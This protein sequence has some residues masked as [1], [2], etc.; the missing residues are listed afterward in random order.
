MLVFNDPFVASD[1]GFGDT[2]FVAASGNGE[3][4]AFGESGEAD[5][6][7]I[8]MYKAADD[9]IT[10][11][12]PVVDLIINREDQVHGLGL[13]YDGTLGVARGDNAY[14]FT[15]DLRLQGVVP[16]APGGAGAVLHPLHANSVSVDN[17]GAPYRPDS[18]LAFVASGDH[19]IDIYDTFHFFKLGQIAIRDVVSGP[20]RAALPFPGDNDGFTCPATVDV[21]DEDGN[22]IGQTLQIF[23]NGNPDTPWE[24]DGGAG[25]NE[26]RC[27]VLKLFGVTDTGGVVVVNVR[28]SDILRN[29]PA[30]L[31]G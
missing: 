1:L 4:V 3:Y 19:T 28:K 22:V 31:G 6:A 27:I 9:R 8:I 18:H 12:I 16:I 5:A 11:G 17:P 15:P 13:N 24:V 14:F 26:D 7:R 29:H 2:T 25:G 23:K 20:L 10:A 30:R 21:T